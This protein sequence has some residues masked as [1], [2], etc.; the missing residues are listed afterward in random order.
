MATPVFYE[1]RVLQGTSIIWLHGNIH[2]TSAQGVCTFKG[3]AQGIC[4]FKG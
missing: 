2:V 1:Y 4:T 3:F